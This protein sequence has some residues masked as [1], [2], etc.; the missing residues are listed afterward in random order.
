MG[1]Y[2][3]SDDSCEGD[4][5]LDLNRLASAILDNTLLLPTSVSNF[6]GPERDIFSI[7]IVDLISISALVRFSLLHAS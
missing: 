2:Q 4:C 1:L 6:P 3:G 5:D 7:A